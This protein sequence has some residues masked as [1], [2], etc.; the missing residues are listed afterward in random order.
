ML[1]EILK[2]EFTRNALTRLAAMLAYPVLRAFKR[3]IDP[4]RHNG[5]TLIGLKGV[6]VK[7][8]GRRRRARLQVRAAQGLHRSRER[9]AR[10]DRAADGG[11]PAL[12]PR[13][14]C[15]GR[16]GGQRCIAAS[17]GTGSYLPAHV[18]TN[19]DLAQRI[20]TSD[21]WIRRAH[22][23]SRAADRRAGGEDQRSR[24]ARRARRARRGGHRAAPTS[25]SSSSRPRRRT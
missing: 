11:M 18:L 4:R 3:R 14:R 1:Y 2:A 20:D 15:R 21:E 16:S 8:H 9:R 19:D 23:H 10:E 6:V 13:A 17:S 12:T 5:A 7:S 24:A 22:R 25:T